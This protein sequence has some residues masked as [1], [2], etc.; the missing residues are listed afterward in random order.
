VDTSMAALIA[1]MYARYPRCTAVAGA[2]RSVSFAD[3]QQRVYRV[4]DALARLGTKPGDR[5]VLWLENG[6]EFLEVEQAVFLFGFVR[7]ALSP[8]LHVD[9]VVQVL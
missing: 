6:Q 1:R 5:V 4:G 9:D 3:L 2:A 7:T 8:K